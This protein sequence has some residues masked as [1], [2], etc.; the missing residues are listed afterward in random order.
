MTTRHTY[1]LDFDAP[2]GEQLDV[3]C[4]FDVQEEE[5]DGPDFT[6]RTQARIVCEFSASLHC[7]YLGQLVLT[8][9]QMV[10]W[11]GADGVQALEGAAADNYQERTPEV[12]S[13]GHPVM[14][15]A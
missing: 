9:A 8:R 2:N 1:A 15:V 5:A 7:V 12:H 13:S 14:G 11:I 3:S 6:D 4:A 10:D